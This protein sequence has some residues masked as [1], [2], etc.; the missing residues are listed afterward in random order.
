[1]SRREQRSL[2]LG[3]AGRGAGAARAR[4]RAA[5]RVARRVGRGRLPAGGAGGRC[6]C[7]RRRPRR[8]LRDALA[9]RRGGRRTCATTSARAC[10]ARRASRTSTCSRCAPARCDAAPDLVVAPGIARRGRGG[11][12][13][14]R[15]G[16]RGGDP[17]RRRDERRR[18]RGA[19]A[20]ALRLRRLAR[21]RRGW[22][23]CSASTCVSRT[24]R[25][26]AGH[27]AA[28]ARPR[29]RRARAAARARPAELRVGDR[30]R[31]RGDALRRPGVDRASAA[32]TSS[33]S[34]CGA[35]RRRASSR[36]SAR[37]ASAAGPDLRGS[38]SGSEGTLGVIT[39]LTLRVRP[40]APRRR[41]EAWLFRSFDAG[42]EALRALAQAEVAPGRRAALRR[43]RR[44]AAVR[45][46]RRAR[47]LAARGCARAGYRPGC[48]LIAGWE[49]DAEDLAPPPRRRAA[50]S[51]GAARC[52]SGAAPGEAWRAAR[53]AGPHLRDALL[54]RGVLVE[55]LETATTWSGLQALHAAVRGGDRRARWPPRRRASAATSR[56][57]IPTARRSTSPS[58]PRQDRD[59][60]AGQWRRRSGR[61]ATRSP[62]A[63][64]TI[65]HHHAVG[66][67]HRAWIAGGGRPRSGSRSCARVKARCD[68]A[69][70]MNPGKLLPD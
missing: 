6:G 28:R 15:R 4:A 34:R 53:F 36:R 47:A 66:R 59:D 64:A 8:A 50:A 17:V 45:A 21:P 41:Y 39:E 32:S 24:A 2:G 14:V 31:L 16:R 19:G 27:A 11:A 13:R 42:C 62:R 5:A 49:G 3:R 60:P 26:R 65:T 57:S 1:M 38:C 67:D 37:P 30:R 20:R 35:R 48:L 40:V 70:V 63:G 54:D 61:P 23:R 55:T 22:T 33:S 43:G 51:R 29:A 69:G 9:R 52:G 68:P 56:T 44:R 58:S 7:R 46:R 12:A 25:V 10:C 18:R